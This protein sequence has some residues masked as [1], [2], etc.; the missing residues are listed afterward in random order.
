MAVAESN[1]LTINGGGLYPFIHIPRGDLEY[2]GVVNG[3]EKAILALRVNNAEPG[4]YYRIRYFNNKPSDKESTS[5]NNGWAVC[6]VLKTSY[7]SNSSKDIDIA[8]AHKTK[9]R[10]DPSLG[11]QR[12]TLE[13]TDNTTIDVVIDP[14]YLSEAAYSGGLSSQSGY[15]HIIDPIFYQYDPSFNDGVKSMMRS[16]V[17]SVRKIESNPSRSILSARYFGMLPID[18]YGQPKFDN[19]LRFAN[20]NTSIPP[21]SITKIMTAFVVAESQIP[22]NT[23]VIINSSDI[24]SGSGQN[25]NE[26]DILSLGDALHN[27]LLV[28]SNT[29]ANAI[30]RTVGEQKG[31]G[32]AKF[33]ELMNEKAQQIGM[34]GTRFK[35]PSGVG[36]SEQRTTVKALM[37]LG[38]HVSRNDVVSS[39]WSKN[40]YTLNVAG[41]NARKIE[42]ASTY[43]EMAQNPWFIGCKTGTFSNWGYNV[44]AHVQLENGYTGIAVIIKADSYDNRAND[45]AMMVNY[46]KSN[47][48]FPAPDRVE[49]KRT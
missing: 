11:I 34:S 29:T 5:I 23:Q 41:P 26:G 13:T 1:S 19:L 30:A 37:L 17:N 44:I 49:Y 9:H 15:Q 16:V 43:G 7:E 28:S 35:N 42:L 8:L 6:K 33:I 46:V 48:A 27:L 39:I 12:F 4:Y 10:V 14:S 20:I 32:Y 25:V 18:P 31:G 24:E 21:A 40:S 38:W 47:Y 3:M 22:L 2:G 36:D 45:L